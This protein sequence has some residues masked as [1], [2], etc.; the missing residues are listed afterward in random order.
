[1]GKFDNSMVG[2]RFT[3]ILDNFTNRLFVC[4]KTYIL[5]ILFGITLILPMDKEEWVVH[6]ELIFN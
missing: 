3:I 6:L 2:D 4:R 1:M 5:R